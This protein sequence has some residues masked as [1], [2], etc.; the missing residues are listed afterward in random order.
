MKSIQGKK[1]LVSG[2]ENHLGV[3]VAQHLL[4][5]GAD[6]FVMSDEKI[7]MNEISN[8]DIIL[9][10]KDLEIQT[11][12]SI[13]DPILNNHLPGLLDLLKLAGM[14]SS[15]FVYASSVAVYGKQKYLP[16]DEDHPLE[17]TLM[18][19]A[20]KLA[21]ELFCKSLALEN[22]FFYTILRY[23]DLY[24]PNICFGE[25]ALFIK[26]ALEKNFI[27]INGLGGQVRSYIYI[28]DA[29]E[30]TIKAI[31]SKPFNQAINLA[32]NEYVSLWHLASIIKHNYCQRSEIKTTN[33]I[34][35]D[36]LE[37]CVNSSKAKELIGFVPKYDLNEGLTKTYNW[38]SSLTKEC[39]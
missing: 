3:M 18:Y 32:G 29:I 37:S 19:G 36:E 27:S 25:P 26:T 14:N 4:E 34:L 1:I 31:I 28:E 11:N 13:N 38:L 33:N 9:Y 5:L 6:V 23:G 7:G 22:G 8:P 30:A 17:P 16:I 15:Y 20:V 21:G 35:L 12:N 39:N 2:G 10:L 24:G